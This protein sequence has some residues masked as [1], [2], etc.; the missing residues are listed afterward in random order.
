[1]AATVYLDAVEFDEFLTG[2]L[3]DRASEPQK[4][5][6]LERASDA[7]DSYLRAAGYQL[8]V[9]NP[10]SDLSAR[11]ADMAR[12]HLAVV[13]RLLPEPASTSALWIDYKSATDWFQ[14]VAAGEVALDLPLVE[15]ETSAG[16]MSIATSVERRWDRA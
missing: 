8:P 6:A 15:G 10:G 12:Y 3:L 11:V 16:R 4:Q 7:A 14:R 1:M 9:A 5:R 13:L 2:D